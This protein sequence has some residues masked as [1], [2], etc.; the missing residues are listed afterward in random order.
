MN[1]LRAR[2]KQTEA[3]LRVPLK[4]KKSNTGTHIRR[5]GMCALM[6]SRLQSLIRQSLEAVLK[7]KFKHCLYLVRPSSLLD[8]DVVGCAGVASTRDAV[9][10]KQGKKYLVHLG[11]MHAVTTGNFCHRRLC[12]PCQVSSREVFLEFLI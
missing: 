6:K 8:F 11:R 4:D 2:Q 12:L 10:Q 9:L 1:Y 5:P 7:L 3:Q